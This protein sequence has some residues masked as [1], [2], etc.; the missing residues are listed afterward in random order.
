[1]MPSVRNTMS[2]TRSSVSIPE[3]SLLES[4]GPAPENPPGLW[5]YRCVCGVEKI[6]LMTKVKRGI[7]THCGCK[8]KENISMS[9]DTYKPAP[10]VRVPN[11]RLTAMSP[12]E[13]RVWRFLCDCGK[14]TDLRKDK[15]FTGVTVSCG[16]ARDESIRER[17]KTHREEYAAKAKATNRA[18]RGV[19][20]A[21][22]DPVVQ[23][24]IKSTNLART[25]YENWTQVPENK[26]KLSENTMR[27]ADQRLAK[28]RETTMAKTGYDHHM[29]AP[30]QAEK[31]LAWRQDPARVAMALAK[32][33][34]TFHDKNGCLLG[35][36]PE[37]RERFSRV[38]K[39]SWQDNH[40]GRI[41]SRRLYFQ[42]D[43][44]VQERQAISVRMST[45][46][47]DPEFRKKICPGKVT[48][49]MLKLASYL[50]AAG[51][52][53][54]VNEFCGNPAR[55]F[56]F[57]I[58][59]NGCLDTL[60]E[61]DGEYNHALIMDPFNPKTDGSRDHLRSLSV[62]KDVKYLAVDS[63]QVEQACQYILSTINQDWLNWVSSIR[64][65]VVGQPFP[66]PQYSVSRMVKDFQNLCK[67]DKFDGAHKRVNPGISL[68]RHFAP[69][70][71]HSSVRGRQSPYDAWNDPATME[72]LILNRVMHANG[73]SS[74]DILKGFSVGG[75][76][77]RV[78]VFAPVLARRLLIQYAPDAVSVVDP[79]C[80]F[81]GRMLG[82]VSLGMS[83]RG[84]D[85][86]E[87]SVREV[88][89]AATF[90]KDNGFSVDASCSKCEI[91][92]TRDD[93]E[94][95]V[96][97]TCPPYGSKESWEGAP[98]SLAAHDYVRMCL[99]SYPN[100]RTMIFVVDE[101][102]RY[103]EHVVE[104]LLSVDRFGNAGKTGKECVLVIRR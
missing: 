42:T 21:S 57:A 70:I 80:G 24:K 69:S 2:R 53:F 34:Q 23:Q 29:K 67:A 20:F 97:L 22:Q 94:Y 16:C 19:D 14:T 55:E 99:E 87:Q 82:A 25:G 63:S 66:Y 35:Q 30:G 64:D 10:G 73:F 9:R 101:P 18:R 72:R 71:W 15:P 5:L 46:M 4:V 103:Q 68:V 79:F 76:A 26:K 7:T 89:A 17:V 3:G 38:T 98:D 50:Q 28:S 84:L 32:A 59:R 95:S 13:G 77:S 104:T 93:H 1:M 81:P 31:A 44:G 49:P 88:I 91:G 37:D 100:V 47:R 43:A 8:T 56:D 85:I 65:A 27:T 92:V 54:R 36:R 39:Q 74:Q 83:Y 86:R 75:V 96:L 48:K 52:D 60:V 6:L 90:L 62:P 78:S 58:Y 102:G 61:V 11:T 40:A 45:A 12:L 41:K 51:V 33:A